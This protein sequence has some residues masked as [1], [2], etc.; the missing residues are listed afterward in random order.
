MFWTFSGREQIVSLLKMRKLPTG[1]R[2][3]THAQY[4]YKMDQGYLV[5]CFENR[6][7]L[8]LS[9]SFYGSHYSHCF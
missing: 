8:K 7:I 2:L 5:H 3:Y 1:S 6:T 4:V 9:A